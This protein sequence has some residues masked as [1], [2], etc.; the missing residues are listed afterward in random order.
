MPHA[1]D[2]FLRVIALAALLTSVYGAMLALVQESSRRAIGY[3]FVSQSALVMAGLDCTS[4]EALTGGLCLWLTSGIAFAGLA[5]C[6]LVL[7]ARRGRLSLSA[8]N[9]GYERMPL[10]AASFLILGLACAG[11]PGTL[12]FVG[13]ELLVGG[14]VGVFPVLGFSVVLAGALTGLAVM[15]MY[16]ALF[17]GRR[18]PGIHLQLRRRELFAFATLAV[19]LIAFGLV[20][21]GVVASRA[22]AARELMGLR[23]EHGLAGAVR[24]RDPGRP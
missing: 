1:P 13:E 6:L 23:Q 9:G 16:F 11:F 7:E 10:L 19:A 14:A 8:L 17:C 18:D 24:A 22:A 2:A 12:G 21:G 15:R 3:L 4:E 20:P 5:R